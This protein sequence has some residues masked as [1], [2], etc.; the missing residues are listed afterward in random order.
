MKKLTTYISLSFSLLL[1]ASCTSDFEEM[2]TSPNQATEVSVTPDLLLPYV[3]EKPVDLTRGSNVRNER[4]NLDGGM[5]WIQHFARRV[6]TYEGD[7]YSPSGDLAQ[8]TWEKLYTESLLNAERIRLIATSEEQKNAHYEGVALVMRSWVFSLL[9]DIFGPVPYTQALQTKGEEEVLKPAYD[10]MPVVYEGV[11]NDLDQA[12]ALLAQDAKPIGGDIMFNGDISRWIKFA[13]SLQLKLL[14]R[15]SSAP[16]FSIDIAAKMTEVAGRP[17]F[18]SNDDFAYLAHSATRPSNNEW[19][20][21]IVNGGRDDWRASV[22][23]VDALNE[24]NDPRVTVFF[25]PTAAGEYAGMPNGLPDALALEYTAQA[26]F[27]GDQMWEPTTPSVIMSYAELQFVLAEAAL[28]GDVAGDPK[29]YLDA[30]IDA[31]FGQ[32]GVET[33]DG[34]LAGQA[35]TLENIM[36]QKWI[37]LYG[38]GIEAWTEYRR[39]GLPDIMR[40]DPNAALLNEGVLPTRLTYPQTEYSLNGEQIQK[41]L[42]LLGGA[43]KADN[44]R[45]KLWWA[46]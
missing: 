29:A 44:M 8:N 27:I 46:Q 34:Y 26:S 24:L 12:V 39:T 20:E 15:A 36:F 35:A 7:T 25:N 31:S 43:D 17:I 3:I 42:D 21:V 23:L 18:T 30:A 45:I 41:A 2:N 9:T 11:I 5:L 37:A 4:L 40:K 1:V 13:N 14:N 10:A 19:N 16:S 32:F 33:P 38:Q 28:R 22:T 6:Y